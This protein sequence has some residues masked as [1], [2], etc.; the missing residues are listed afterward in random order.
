MDDFYSTFGSAFQT[1][2]GAYT[3]YQ[4]YN[5]SPS[6][7]VYPASASPAAAPAGPAPAAAGGGMML[8]VILGL[9]ALLVVFLI[10]R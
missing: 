2:L 7:D 5:S 3:Q 10:L 8:Y 4:Q 6:N 9:L 1:G